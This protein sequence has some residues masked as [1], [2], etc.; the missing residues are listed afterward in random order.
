[1]SYIGNK[2][3]IINTVA[4]IKQL[5]EALEDRKGEDLMVLDVRKLSTVT[6][7]H[8]LCTGNNP[9]HLK[10]LVEACEASLEGEGVKAYRHSGTPESGWMILD[11]LHVVV[12]VFREEARKHYALETL[13]KD[14]PRVA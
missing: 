2:E 13:W 5:R 6:D 7:Y 1:M 12:H 10:A 14:A 11:Y 8:V 9:R 3:P 4:L